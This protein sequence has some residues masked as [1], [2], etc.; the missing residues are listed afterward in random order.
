MPINAGGIWNR[1]KPDSEEL[2]KPSQLANEL[3]LALVTTL[4]LSKR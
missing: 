1:V 4:L 2:R 3:H